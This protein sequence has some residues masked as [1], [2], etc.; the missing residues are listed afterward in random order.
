MLKSS[1]EA[2]KEREKSYLGLSLLIISVLPVSSIGQE[3]ICQELLLM[4]PV[5][6][7]C[8]S[9]GKEKKKTK[10]AFGREEIE[11]SMGLWITVVLLAYN[12]FV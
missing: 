5:F 2:E 7:C 8:C 11:I 12:L 6:P 9:I 4:Y 3:V 1:Q 10:N